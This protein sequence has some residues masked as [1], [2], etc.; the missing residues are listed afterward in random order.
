MMI[1]FEEFV[2]VK[3]IIVDFAKLKLKSDGGS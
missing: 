3:N 1:S 2:N